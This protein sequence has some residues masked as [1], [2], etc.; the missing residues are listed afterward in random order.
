M[1]QL[2]AIS[3]G[4]VQEFIAA[5]RRT[6]D[7]WF[8]S[9]LL[10]E[11]SRAVA[12]SIEKNGDCELIFPASTEA[13][14]VANV[15][16]GEIAEGDPAQIAAYAKSAA[17][18]RWREFADQAKTEAS[19]LIREDVWNDQIN[20][21]IEFY[22]AWVTCSEDDYQADRRK[23]MRLLA[24][25]K[26]CRD[27]TQ[28]GFNDVGLP[29]SS[30][31]G[32]RPTVLKGP[33]PEEPRNTYREHWPR[34]LRLASGEQLDVVGVTKRLG[35]TPGEAHPRYA[36]VARIAAETWLRGI[37][38][39]PQFGTLKN[40]CESVPG[41]N[42][43]SEEHFD[44]FPFEG[45]VVYKNRHADLLEELGP[46][47]KEPLA[48]VAQVLEKIK[49]EPSPYLAVL[50]ADGDRMGAAISELS[51]PALN[52]TVSSV[53]AGFAGEAKTIVTKHRGV[54]VYAGGD[55]VLAFLPVDSCLPCARELHDCFGDMLGKYNNSSESPTLSVGIAI[56]HFMENLEDLLNY[57]RA[58]EK[59][60]KQVAGK[61]AL[62]IHLHKRGGS[63]I[64]V[65]TKWSDKP[66]VRLVRF[67][68]LLNSGTLPRK[69]PY[70]LRAMAI[71]YDPWPDNPSTSTVI[72]QDLYRLIAKKT[73]RS[74]EKV[75][76][77]LEDKLRNINSAKDLLE[78]AHELLVAKHIADALRLVGEQSPQRAEPV[79]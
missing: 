34:A 63:P 15:I 41:L 78:F 58:A 47:V 35:K 22:A 14:N 33:G 37:H 56:G 29:K 5:A 67:A 2:L 9:Y 77:A 28:P 54:L 64:Q 20:D 65:Q 72:Q 42:R 1:S 19:S 7:L 59:S 53:L 52:R 55:D 13:S 75:Q 4:P 12:Q 16:L 6:R 43:V 32:Q 30:L 21:V 71:L 60:A 66:E 76:A 31:D 57:G 3:V 23:L 46:Q 50:V 18:K 40:A 62:A 73:S 39:H 26:N 45:T 61:D 10:S 48:E 8:G 38:K 49:S 68:Q 27:F 17:Q 70:D 79:S 44:Y 51:S 25:R 74:M 11:I 36:S 69:L 24:G